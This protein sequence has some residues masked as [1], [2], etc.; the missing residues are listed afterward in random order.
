[1]FKTLAF[2][3]LCSAGLAPLYGAENERL[4]FTPAGLSGLSV[5]TETGAITADGVPKGEVLVEIFDNDP[6]KCRLTAAVEGG[7]LVL[8]AEGKPVPVTLG[9]KNFLSFFNKRKELHNCRAGFKIS[10]PAALDLDAES[11]TGDIHLS[12]L[13]GN[14][15]VNSGTG[16]L[17]GEVC[18]RQL[19]VKSGTGEVRLKGLCGPARV[20]TGTGTVNLHWAKAPA[21]GEVTV[22]TG[23]SEISLVFPRGAKFTAE[24]ASGTGSINNEFKDGGGFKVSARSGTGGISVKK[25]LD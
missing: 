5:A 3:F 4:T 15:D 20:K 23:T 24:L 19:A 13:S 1:M 18:A 7:K 12:K 16:G 17:D 14:I 8:K 6:E 21:S 9:W 25:A 11:G 22:V 2:V 10:A